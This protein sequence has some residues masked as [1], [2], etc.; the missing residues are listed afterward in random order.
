MWYKFGYLGTATIFNSFHGAVVFLFL[1]SSYHLDSPL[2]F[3]RSH[4]IFEFELKTRTGRVTY[5]QAD[6]L[7][8]R[9]GG[10][11]NHPEVRGLANFAFIFPCKKKG[12]Q[13]SCQMD[14]TNWSL[15]GDE[16][17]FQS[18]SWSHGGLLAFFK[19][20]FLPSVGAALCDSNWFLGVPRN[21]TQ[22]QVGLKFWTTFRVLLWTF[23]V[24]LIP[25][26]WL[27]DCFVDLN[28]FSCITFVLHSRL[29]TLVPSMISSWFRNS[30]FIDVFIILQPKMCQSMFA[31]LHADHLDALARFHWKKQQIVYFCKVSAELISCPVV[32]CLGV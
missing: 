25:V 20:K 9:R 11:W 4:G 28:G 27:D 22:L 21:Q 17:S 19:N 10:E 24:K 8:V 31:S 2:Y 6:E 5:R 1:L 3:T 32:Q 12:R 16:M 23:G 26:W 7:C 14:K 30:G 15:W 18:K 29:K 13:C